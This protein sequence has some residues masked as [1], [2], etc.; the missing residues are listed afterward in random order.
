MNSSIVSISEILHNASSL[1]SVGFSQ[2]YSYD[3]L[4]AEEYFEE[5]LENSTQDTPIF[6][7]IL[8]LEKYNRKLTVIDGLQ[9]I[10]TICLLLSAL[11][12]IYKNTSKKNEEA[13]KK[14][15]K[16]YL[17][18]STKKPK[19]NLGNQEQEIYKKILF[20]EKLSQEEMKSNLYQVYDM[21]LKKINGHRISGTHLFAII[22][23]IRFMV[24]LTDKSEISIRELYEVLN[25]NKNKSQINL[26]ADFLSQKDIYAASIW[27]KTM[28]EYKSLSMNSF[29][30]NFVK[31]FLTVQNEGEAPKENAL[32]NKF[33]SY[34][35]TISKY[36]TP[37]EIVE[38]LVK[39]SQ[40]YLSI[41]KA[42]F[43]D[44]EIKEQIVILNSNKGQD[45]Y[46]YLMEVLDDYNNKLINREVLL[47]ILNM[48]NSIVIKR[49]QD[50]QSH[51]EIDF[52]NLSKELN[53]ML[54]MPDY[55]AQMIDES[56][57]TINDINKLSTKN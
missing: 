45:A 34:F 25:A 6:S 22:S 19:L 57:L 33:K 43:E 21:F 10:T 37:T 20:G 26:I 18:N 32:Y 8:I 55:T 50:S 46:S 48:I 40:Y 9:R 38:N 14:V 7:G 30:E 35:T 17:V 13:R 3:A 39:Y 56:Q 1:T 47:E 53:R 51:I 15:F 49:S 11:C 27:Q 12:K 44:D 2:G 54:I 31:D 5:L 28:N 36:K 29:L 23:R 16:R 42:D 4:N 52:A 24:V 41:I